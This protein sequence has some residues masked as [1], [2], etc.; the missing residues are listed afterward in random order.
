MT[1]EKFDVLGMTCASCVAH[2]EK[3]VSKLEGV[4]TVNVNLLTN[5]MSVS[6]NE[7]QLDAGLIEKSV[8]NAGYEAHLHAERVDDFTVDI[9][10]ID[11][12]QKEQAELKMRWWVSFVFLLPLLYLSMGGMLGLPYPM[13]FHTPENALIFAFIQFWL[14]MPIVFVNRK[15]FINGFKTLLDRKSTRLNSSH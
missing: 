6:F 7:L 11:Y 5:S 13:A 15:Y 10:K 9:P 1:T 8:E 3:S 12:V 4:N 2:V 14:S